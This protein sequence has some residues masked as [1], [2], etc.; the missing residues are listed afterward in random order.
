[1]TSKINKGMGKMDMKHKL[2][3]IMV[4]TAILVLFSVSIAHAAFFDTAGKSARAIGMGEVFLA[5]SGDAS[6][7]W[8]NPAGLTKF[9]T[10]QLSIGYGK[11]VAFISELMSSQINFVTPLGENSGIGLGFAYGGIDVASDM[12]IS[13]AYGL[14]LG[15][16]FS[17]GGNVKI[18]RWAAEG[19]DIV[20]GTVGTTDDDIS[21]M[22]F[23]LD[24]S[25]AYSLGELMGLDD[26]I[27]GV[28]VKDAIMPNISESGDDGGKLP[29]EI[30]IG[31]L[32]QRNDLIISGDAAFV[33]GVTILRVGAESGITGSNLKIRGGFIYGS[34]FEEELEKA[35]VDVGLGYTFRSLGF[36]YAYN[37]PIAFK[38]TGGRHYV[39]FGISF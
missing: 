34:D 29:M 11:P 39:S 20:W 21:K 22:S 27:T 31:V 7:Y 13:G 38:E 1:M 12:V 35:D 4:F 6:G 8:Y 24:L 30:G 9:E 25:A 2:K 3:S 15:E 28:Y 37:L 17:V 23:S 26:F 32:A 14:S 16:S 5:S 18:M 10:K 33:D 19:Q 36:D